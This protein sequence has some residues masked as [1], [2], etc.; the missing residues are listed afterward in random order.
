MP[1]CDGP[2]LTRRIRASRQHKDIT[3]L[4]LTSLS[5]DED[6]CEGRDARVTAYL[7]KSDD[8]AL[9]APVRAYMGARV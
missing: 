1:N 4:A 5:S 2:Q 6:Q 7:I 8:A 3:V 9:V